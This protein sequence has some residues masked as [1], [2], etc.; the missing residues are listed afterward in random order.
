MRHIHPFP[1][2]MAPEI[3]LAKIQELKS[4]QTVLDP[5]CGSGMVL[6]Q[7][8]RNGLHSIG[9]DLDPLAKIISK[10]G[11]TQASEKKIR[12]AFAT[13]LDTAQRLM[14]SPSAVHIDW[15]DDNP[16]TAVY[17]QFW[18]HENQIAQLRPLIYALF[19][20]PIVKDTKIL[21]VL[22]VALSRLIITKE[23]KASLARDTAHSRPHRTITENDFDIFEALP[24]SIEH[25]L[26]ALASD[27]IEIN[28]K[29]Y[30]G[31]AR[32]LG[33][34]GDKSVDAIITSPPYLNA[35]DYMRGHRL[36]L[37]WFGYS[38]DHLRTIRAR[39]IGAESANRKKLQGSFLE[40]E[41]NLEVSG[42]SDKQKFMLCRY[43]R[44][45]QAQTHAAYRVLK[46]GASATYVI[47]NSNLKGVYIRNSEL[48]KKAAAQAGFKLVGEKERDIPDNR[49]YLPVNIN[50]NSSLSTRMRTEHIIEF[51]RPRLN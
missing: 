25:V 36:A 46:T 24:K 12:L 17:I 22:K 16:E 49:R 44:D 32:K 11:A 30:L 3:A 51:E 47:G 40:I 28:T 27:N 41:N 42:L 34:L 1:A 48:L 2:R 15:I 26:K 9:F 13:W 19:C 18:F 20:K 23:P 14:S 21:D 7:A 38:L 50:K 4:G 31:D 33:R 39:S 10:V 29:T 35:I 45:L 8:A 37:V 5:M 6:S 43:H